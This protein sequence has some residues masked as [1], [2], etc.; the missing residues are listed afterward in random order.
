[1]KDRQTLSHVKWGYEYHIVFK[2]DPFQPDLAFYI[3]RRPDIKRMN[4]GAAVLLNYE[5]FG[6]LGKTFNIATL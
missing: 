5:D 3:H 6:G 1:M 4:E 2:K